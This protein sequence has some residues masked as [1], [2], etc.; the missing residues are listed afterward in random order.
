MALRMALFRPPPTLYLLAVSADS[1][2]SAVEFGVIVQH[3]VVEVKV[4]PVV[5]L[6]SEVIR[7]L[8]WMSSMP[9]AMTVKGVLSLR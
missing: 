2:D 3:I 5:V 4:I 1:A 6:V 8:L 7:V 9:A